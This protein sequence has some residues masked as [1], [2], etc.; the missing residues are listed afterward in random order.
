[1]HQDVWR[2]SPRSGLPL[3]EVVVLLWI[4]ALRL[5]SKFVPH[6]NSVQHLEDLW[7]FIELLG[8]LQN[9]G[10]AGHATPRT[11]EREVVW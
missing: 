2:S 5:S 11:C 3:R 4:V 10:L 1:M 9:P 6:T 7:Q 8:V